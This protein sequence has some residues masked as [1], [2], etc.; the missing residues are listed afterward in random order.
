M[1]T[2][3]L[4]I[5]LESDNTLVT[6]YDSLKYLRSH[7][8]NDCRIF[9]GSRGLKENTDAEWYPYFTVTDKDNDT[10]ELSP[11]EVLGGAA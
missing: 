8:K 2:Y 7:W 5:V 10:R 4:N 6:S 3:Y 1:K 9:L 11:G